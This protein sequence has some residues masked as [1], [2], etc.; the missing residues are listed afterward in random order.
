MIV[1]RIEQDERETRVIW[2]QGLHGS[3]P[4]SPKT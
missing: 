1:Q 4:G 3:S 2:R